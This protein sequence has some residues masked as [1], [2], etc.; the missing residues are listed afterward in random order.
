MKYSQPD[1][2]RFSED[3]IHIS[4]WA[5]KKLGVLELS[6]DEFHGADFGCGCG[7]VGLEFLAKIEKSLKFDFFEVQ[8]PFKEHFEKNVKIFS[9]LEEK[10][11]RFF[12]LNLKSLKVEEFKN[13]YDLILSNPPYFNVD[14]NRMGASALRNNCRFFTNLSFEEWIEVIFYCLKVGGSTCFSMRDPDKKKDFL[15]THFKN[16]VNLTFKYLKDKTTLVFLFV[17]EK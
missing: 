2:Y 12:N 7:I 10:Q 13:N 3:S 6:P 1:F 9:L 16:K 5:A 14:E 11:I 15:E 17:L 4:S 8:K